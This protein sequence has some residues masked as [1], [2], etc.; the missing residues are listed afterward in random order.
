M[1]NI[2]MSPE[3]LQELLTAAVAAALAAQP[4]ADKPNTLVDG[5][6]ERSLKNEILA[7]KAFKKAGFGNVEPHKDI[8]TYNRWLAEGRKVI[9]GE[10][11]VKVKNLRL[12]HIKQTKVI[13]AEEKADALAKVQ[14]AI[15][16]Y[17]EQKNTNNVTPL[18]PAS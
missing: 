1:T 16:E 17:D 7:V 9:P 11:G 13:S 8:K 2:T 10:H 15:K 4:K 12:F 3:K 14:K 18:H 6:T 5:K